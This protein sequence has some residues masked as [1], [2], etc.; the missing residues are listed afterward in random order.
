[1]YSKNLVCDVSTE[2]MRNAAAISSVPI[3]ALFLGVRY[4]PSAPS[5]V[6]PTENMTTLMV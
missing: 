3:N 2:E 1:M 4:F 5:T 6:M